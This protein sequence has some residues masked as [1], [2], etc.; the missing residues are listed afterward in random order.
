MLP[1]WFYLFIILEIYWVKKKVQE[2]YKMKSNLKIVRLNILR[3]IWLIE[4]ALF[5]K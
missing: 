3:H 1:D 5:K 4:N 2:W